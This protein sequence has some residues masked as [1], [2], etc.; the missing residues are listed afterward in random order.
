MDNLSTNSKHLFKQKQYDI[1]CQKT[2]LKFC[3]WYDIFMEKYIL[4]TNIFFNMEAGLNLG[5]NTQEVVEKITQIASQRRQQQKAEFYMAPRVVE[6]FLSFFEDK[7]QELIKNFLAAIIV[8]SPDISQ[9]SIPAS[10]FYLLVEDIRARSYRGL[11]VGEEEMQKIAQAFIHTEDLNKK[12]FQIKV[13][14]FIKN[15]RDR[16][17]HATRFGFLDSLAD[18]DTILLA[19]ELDGTIISTDEGVLHW[20]RIFG[21][22]EIPPSAVQQRLH[23]AQ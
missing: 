4:D 16:Y 23:E 2:S 13:G 8:K 21:A 12:E 17:R 1:S 3:L 18:L 6:E 15:F 5:K 14:S 20:S 11:S 10:V 7:N 22:R 19:K 9:V